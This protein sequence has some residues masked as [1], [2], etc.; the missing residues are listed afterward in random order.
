MAYINNY[1][2]TKT[3]LVLNK[4]L[5][6]FFPIEKNWYKLKFPKLGYMANF[7][8]GLDWFSK[9]ARFE[10]CLNLPKDSCIGNLVSRVLVLGSGLEIYEVGPSGRFRSWW[11]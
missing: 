11:I 6:H 1:F 5:F 8:M 10:C 3:L 4:K 2:L 9:S 7:H